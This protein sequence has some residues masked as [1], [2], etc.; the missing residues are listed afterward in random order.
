MEYADFWQKKR[1]PLKV[2]FHPYD[3]VPGYDAGYMDAFM[4]S[5]HAW[6]VATD[7]MVTFEFVDKESEADIDVQWTPDTTKWLKK[8][9]GHELGLCSHRSL[10]NEGIDHASILLLT[11]VHQKKVGLQAMQWASLHELGHALGLG[12]SGR[13]SDVMKRCVGVRTITPEG[14]STLEAKNVDVKL[15][16]RDVTTIKIVYAAKKKLDIIRQKNL[17]KQ[18]TCIELYNEAYNQISQGDSGQAVIFLHEAINL[19]SSF[20]PAMQNLMV[21]YYNNGV[22]LFNKQHYSEALEVLERATELAR[23]VGTVSEQRAMLAIEQKCMLAARAPRSGTTAGD[24]F[25]TGVYTGR[26]R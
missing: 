18:R 2:Y 26:S 16:A 8:P 1:M 6:S 13:Q 19:D 25:S 11:K 15:S 17:G 3:D 5:C 24:S 10:D 9:D 22:E 20:K 21:A 7:N 4:S 23:K 14:E 12:H